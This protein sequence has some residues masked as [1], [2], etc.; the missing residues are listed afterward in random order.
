MEI[1]ERL[2]LLV[3]AVFQGNKQEDWT[4]LIPSAVREEL[5]QS[6][7]S[8]ADAKGSEADV[9]DRAS[10]KQ[11]IDIVLSRWALFQ[12]ILN[13]KA[14]IQSRLNE[15]R[16]VR[17]ALVHGYQP[18]PDY[19]VKVAITLSELG[20]RLPLGASRAGGMRQLST[21]PALFGHSILWADDMPANNYWPRRLL[22]G[23]GADVVPVLSNDEAVEEAKRRDFDVVVSDIDR[24][25]GE[26]GSKLGLRLKT[27][28]VD[29]PIVFFISSVDSSMPIP[30][31]GVAI[32][33]DVVAMLTSVLSILRPDATV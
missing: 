24:G 12:P 19:K 17:N 15:M 28:G 31:G 2:K 6:P 13:D 16:E 7:S 33:N 9:L 22:T 10:L 23:W 8:A 4:R 20:G 5:K 1:E 14:W 3:R 32:S 25:R 29:V 27:I 18:D 11:L 21:G 30:Y 26:P